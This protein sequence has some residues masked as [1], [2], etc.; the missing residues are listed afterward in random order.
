[1]ES[2]IDRVLAAYTYRQNEFNRMETASRR[3]GKL[4]ETAER[5]AKLKANHIAR[6]DQ[7]AAKID[8]VEEKT[9]GAFAKAHAIVDAQ[10]ADVDAMDSELSQLSNQ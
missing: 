3:M 4:Q 5:I 10:D 9:P 6:S 1:M 8:A 7:L 2:K